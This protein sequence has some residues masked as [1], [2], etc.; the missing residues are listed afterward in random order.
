ME[1][2][3]TFRNDNNERNRKKRLGTHFMLWAINFHPPGSQSQINKINSREIAGE[4]KFNAYFIGI[5]E[6]F[7]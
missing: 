1:N 7:T 4:T 2:K 6:D 3:E 5:A